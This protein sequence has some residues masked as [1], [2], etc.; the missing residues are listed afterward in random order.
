MEQILGIAIVGIGVWLVVDKDS[1]Q[2]VDEFVK[3][4]SDDFIINYSRVA[5]P[6]FYETLS[7]LLIAFGAVVVIIA[8]LGYCGAMRESQVLLG[9]CFCCLFIIFG[10]LVG[11]G[12][13]VYIEK[14][15]IDVDE[16]RLKPVVREMIDDAIKKYETDDASRDFMDQVQLKFDCC[17]GSRAVLDYSPMTSIPDSCKLM[18]R[19]TGCVDPYYEH[20]KSHIGVKQFFSDKMTIAMAVALGVAGALTQRQ[21]LNNSPMNTRA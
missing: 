1:G 17:G 3:E 21:L 19:A 8:F 11:I 20:V 16:T 9:A 15:D 14:D 18:N 12:I 7:Y 10:A 4:T 6:S 5:E 13:W 2:F